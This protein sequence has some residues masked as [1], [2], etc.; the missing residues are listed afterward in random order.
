MIT[1]NVV[2]TYRRENHRAVLA[3]SRALLT[4]LYELG[5][6]T[7][8]LDQVE[9]IRTHLT[10][11]GVLEGRAPALLAL[12]VVESLELV[13]EMVKDVRAAI[14]QRAPQRGGRAPTPW[15]PPAN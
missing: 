14:P 11:P 2:D 6:E 3:S 10:A 13:A 12:A 8:Q 7:E 15:Q 5:E 4:T 1:D 9:R